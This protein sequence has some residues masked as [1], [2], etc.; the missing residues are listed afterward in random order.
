MATYF[1]FGKY[2]HEAIKEIS[3]ERTKK[4]I[5]MIEKNGG[6]VKSGYAL[7]GEFD[8]V[9]IVDFPDIN[10]AMKASVGLTQLL[11]IAFSTSPAVSIEE[12]DKMMG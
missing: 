10:Q 8:L 6:K 4:S 1:M 3:A 2:S 12:F 9:L 7:L 5:A 11:G